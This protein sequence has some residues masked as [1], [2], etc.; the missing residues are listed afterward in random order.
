VSDEDERPRDA[1]S[2]AAP[3]S[4]ASDQPDLSWSEAAAPDDISALAKDIQ[5]YHRE[6]RAARRHERFGRYAVRPGASAL[7]ATI[8]VLAIVAVLVT[9]I[10]GLGPHRSPTTLPALPLASPTAAAGTVGGLLPATGLT[11]ATGD[12]VIAQNLRPGVVAVLPSGCV[13]CADLVVSLARSASAASHDRIPTYVVAPADSA[14]ADAL[15]GQ[16]ASEDAVFTVDGSG[17]ADALDREGLTLALVGQ[18]GTIRQI[19]RNASVATTDL[20]KADV[21]ALLLHPG[22]IG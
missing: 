20:L 11:S 5:A 16:L 17:L 4:P 15:R 18:D 10:T 12:T 7:T 8:G 19:Y 1:G 13:G 9:L 6:R 14:D 2:A 22:T 3:G 21:T